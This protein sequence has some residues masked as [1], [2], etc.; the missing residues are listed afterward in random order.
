M[1]QNLQMENWGDVLAV[2]LLQVAMDEG[3]EIVI[4]VPTLEIKEDLELRV[5]TLIILGDENAD[6]ISIQ[7]ASTH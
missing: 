5:H 2:A 7:L 4:P 1:T 3:C 6:R